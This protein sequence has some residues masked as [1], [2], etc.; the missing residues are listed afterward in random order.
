MA[1]PNNYYDETLNRASVPTPVPVQNSYI[2]E[3]A[4]LDPALTA[5]TSMTAAGL[6]SP[7][8][9]TMSNIGAAVQVRDARQESL[10]ISQKQLDENIRKAVEKAGYDSVL[11]ESNRSL[12]SALPYELANTIFD[13]PSQGYW[14]TLSLWEQ[15][16]HLGKEV[17]KFAWNVVK[18]I[19]REVIKAPLRL[20]HGLFDLTTRAMD[21][22]TG[23]EPGTNPA[24]DNLRTKREGY[25]LPVLGEVRG[26]GGSYDEG[27]AMGLSPFASAVKATG[28][29]AGDLAMTASLTEAVGAAF[30]PRVVTVQKGVTGQDFRPLQAQQ[31]EQIKVKPGANKLSTGEAVFGEATQNPNISYFKL[32]GTA[33]SKYGGNSNN[34]FLKLTPAGEGLAQVSVVQIRKS[35]FEKSKDILANKFGRGK[36]SQGPLGPEL[37]LESG[38]IKYDPTALT[39][40]AP[41]TKIA[42]AQVEGISPTADLQTLL[43]SMGKKASSVS[44][45]EAYQF[46]S[47]NVEENLTFDDALARLDSGNQILYNKIGQDVD[48]QLGYQSQS[49]NALG[50][51]SDGA[52]NTVFNAIQKVNSFEELR[53]STAVKGKIGKQKAVIPFM[54]NP[55]GA[56]TLFMADIKGIQLP[57][58]RAK[59][60]EMGISF[61]TLVPD[62]GGVKVVVFDPGSQLSAQMAKF[63]ET[64]KVNVDIRK[65]QGEFLGS[66]ASREAGALEYDKVIKGY[67]SNIANQKTYNPNLSSKTQ[68][69]YAEKFIDPYTKARLNKKMPITAAGKGVPNDLPAVMAKPLKGYANSLVNGKQT[70]QILGITAEKELSDVGLQA[71]VKTI[72]GKDNLFELTQS[73]AFDVAETVR[74]FANVDDIPESDS[75]VILRS[76]THP[77]R[78]W[79]E[80]AERE[81]GFPAY[82]EVFLPLETASRVLKVYSDRWMQKSRDV[83]GE[84]ADP[85]FVE[86][87]RIINSY[88]EGDKGAIINNPALTPETKMELTRIG[89]WLTETYKDMFSLMG[90]KSTKY[91]GEYAPKIRKVGGINNLYKTKEMPQEIKPFFEFEREGSLSPLEDDALALFDIYTRAIGKKQFLAE[92]VKN[93]TIQMGKMPEN[94]KVAVNDYV[95]EKLGYKDKTSEVMD[96]LSKKLSK[97]TNGYLP[98]DIIKQVIDFGMTT[99]YAGA[100]GLPRI[101]PLLRDAAQPLL[102]TYPELGPKYFAIGIRRYAKEGAQKI[103]DK[104]FI[105]DMGV[106]YGAELVSQSRQGVVGRAVSFYEKLNKLAMKPYAAG[107]SRNRAI[108]YYGL[109]ARFDDAWKNFQSGKIDYSQFE[110]DIDMAGFNPTLRKV[111][112]KEFLKNTDES[113]SNAKDLMAM[114]ILDKT[115]FPYRKG[116]ESR[117]HYGLK[118]KLGLQFAQWSWEYAFTLKSWVARGQWDK[119]VRWLGMSAAVKRSI[120][121]SS[122]VDVKDWMGFGPFTG[123]PLGPLGKAGA[124]AI[125]GIN[126]SFTGM[127]EEV[128]KNWK[129]IANSMKI[130]GGIL[131]GV[132]AQKISNFWNSVKR[133]EEGTVVSTDVDPDKKFGIWSTNGKLIRWVDFSELLQTLMSFNSKSGLE[134]SERIS[135]AQKSNIEY[136]NKMNEAMNYLIDGNYNKFDKTVIDNNLTIPDIS[137]KMKSYYMPL[138]ERIFERL[139]MQLKEKYFNAFYPIDK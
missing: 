78:Y 106:P 54:T 100:L 107:D 119:V 115:Q 82:S 27:I 75:S 135:N 8:Q 62:K 60:D 51:W 55:G 7:S 35:L 19:P 68:Q 42:G 45:A 4:K 15:T 56:D 130:Y 122:N 131:S 83:F 118:G 112:E 18:A 109:E 76:Y 77:A 84:F 72:T 126:A 139:P 71:I 50:D 123:F 30:K 134:Q 87:R 125:A 22:L 47:P 96:N 67:E 37:K 70:D 14:E 6:P 86:E 63:E 113:L 11:K 21:K 88:I 129:D 44:M 3:P 41:E 105:V 124:S 25:T 16:K 102:T 74:N 101:M 104:G 32:P 108:T 128:N 95:Q 48:Q 46:Y 61:R 133:Y 110:R 17:P 116:S 43:G 91:F 13:M 85:K 69:P 66:D 136:N 121:E 97:N 1:R 26:V 24:L 29:F 52:E 64:F 137:N 138:D 120:E 9:N 114:D 92:P 49:F 12:A 81:L 127:D 58:L 28:E 98:E 99:S 90:I 53:Y 89:D 2:Q 103:K 40:L 79:M 33:A 132:G 36:V 39:K 59:L 65:G 20:Q 34:T 73:E 117:L 111:L 94:L 5:Q 10:G 23:Y 93:A 80:S 57:E 38:T 31:I